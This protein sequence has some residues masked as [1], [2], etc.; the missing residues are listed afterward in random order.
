MFPYRAIFG[1]HRPQVPYGRRSN[2]L[3]SATYKLQGS[4]IS[5]DDAKHVT[6]QGVGSGATVIDGEL[7]SVLFQLKAAHLYLYGVHLING[8]A[9]A[10]GGGVHASEGAS[11]ALYESHITNCMAGE[12]GGGLFAQDSNV[13]LHHSIFFNCSAGSDG[14]GVSAVGV[15]SFSLVASEMNQ[16][17]SGRY[18][19][20]IFSKDP[21]GSVALLDT[22]IRNCVADAD[23]GGL[24]ARHSNACC[25][26]NVMLR[27]CVISS[28]TAHSRGGGLGIHDHGIRCQICHGVVHT[29]ETCSNTCRYPDDEECAEIWTT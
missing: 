23:G 13:E 26:L 29:E 14:G 1:K 12:F 15:R 20:G 6:L 21:Q 19:G 4:P 16:C 25:E 2:A 5:I 10:S 27:G 9:A 7:L 11:L 28:C 18:G 24:L 22:T 3:T 8:N 17:T